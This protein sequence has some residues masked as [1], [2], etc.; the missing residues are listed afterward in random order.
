M[1]YFWQHQN[2]SEMQMLSG[3]GKAKY[4]PLIILFALAILQSCRKNPEEMSND[5]LAKEISE[6]KV[7][8][9]LLEYARKAK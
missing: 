1:H 7:Y 5:E 8:R 9:E 4:I 6:K 3:Q 2:A